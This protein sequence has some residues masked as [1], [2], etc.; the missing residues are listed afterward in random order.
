MVG[1]GLLSEKNSNNQ[2]C[3]DYELV[4]L[5]SVT[6]GP[7]ITSSP[8]EVVNIGGKCWDIDIQPS[9]ISN[10][11]SE[12]RALNCP[13]SGLQG[14]IGHEDHRTLSSTQD[15]TSSYK[16]D[17]FLQKFSFLGSLN[18][19]KNIIMNTWSH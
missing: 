6:K 3:I 5:T 12:Q 8:L 2:D 18:F 17:W 7:F 13:E 15:I 19:S 11:H 9:Q 10:S 16:G 14:S 1:S 4:D